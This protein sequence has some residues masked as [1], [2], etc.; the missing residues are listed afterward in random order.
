[1]KTPV[2]TLALLSLV[3]GAHSARA[4]TVYDPAVHAQII[5]GTAQ[6]VAK[7]V[8]MIN[9]QVQQITNLKEQLD[10]FNQYKER[11]GNPASVALAA[12][13][14]APADLV[15]AEIVIDGRA[16]VASASGSGAVTFDGHGLYAAVGATF[17]TPQGASVERQQAEFKPYDAIH[18]ATDN[19]LAVS[20]DA[21]QRRKALKQEIAQQL[22]ALKA[23]K[24]DAEVQKVSA[25]LTTLN[26]ALE[27]VDHEVQQA[28][29]SA[30]VQDVANRNVE[31]QRQHAR[32]EERKAEFHEAMGNFQEKFKVMSQ[33]SAFPVD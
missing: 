3:V 20:Q 16:L 4:I 15:R 14:V 10:S 28:L 22:A 9:N 24:T 13:K 2:L 12:I 31:R 23:A 6:E 18:K 26:A 11:F 17:K 1:M 33:P 29:A 19:Y 27:G 8:E 5:A 25:G 32:R 21:S 30:L 7:F